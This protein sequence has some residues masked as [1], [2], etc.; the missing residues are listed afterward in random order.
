MLPRLVTSR[1]KRCTVAVPIPMIRGNGA[2]RTAG[3][4]PSLLQAR[5]RSSGRPLAFTPVLR[6]YPRREWWRLLWPALVIDVDPR[7]VE[8]VKVAAESKTTASPLEGLGLCGGHRIVLVGPLLARAGVRSQPVDGHLA[9]NQDLAGDDLGISL[10][11][12]DVVHRDRLVRASPALRP[13][14]RIQTFGVSTRVGIRYD[15]PARAVVGGV[16]HPPQNLADR[17]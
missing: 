11:A 9:G 6:H 7:R 15:L 17:K 1:R 10:G 5:C 12:S 13:D 2:V 16:G 14:Q 3:R 8:V 4:L